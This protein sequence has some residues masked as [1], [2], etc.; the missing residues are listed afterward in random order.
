MTW[1][2]YGTS[3]IGDNI[4]WISEPDSSTIVDT[5]TTDEAVFSEIRTI[6]KNIHPSNIISQLLGTNCVQR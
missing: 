1:G 5:A 6:P 4:V 3:W 2:S